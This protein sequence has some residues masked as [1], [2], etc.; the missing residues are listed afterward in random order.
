MGG[1]RVSPKFSFQPDSLTVMNTFV[2]ILVMP[3]IEQRSVLLS[4]RLLL[5]NKKSGWPSGAVFLQGENMIEKNEMNNLCDSKHFTNIL[6]NASSDRL[7][8]SIRS[9]MF[10]LFFSLQKYEQS[11]KNVHSLVKLFHRLKNGFLRCEK[12]VITRL[13]IRLLSQKKRKPKTMFL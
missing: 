5:T 9:F 10:Y 12:S 11:M 13:N 2:V 6:H 4:R 7:F 3:N 1:K 8:W